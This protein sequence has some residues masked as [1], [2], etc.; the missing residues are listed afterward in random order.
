VFK[1][2]E[3]LLRIYGLDSAFYKTIEP[4]IALPH[5]TKREVPQNEVVPSK[6]KLS[7]KQFNINTAD[8]TT[9]QQLYG[10]GPTLSKRII[11]YREKLGGFVSKEQFYEIYGLD[12]MVINRLAIACFI[13]DGFE[14]KRLDINEVT[15]RE[16]EAHPYVSK[17]I[18]K[19]IV[20]Y[21]FQHGKFTAVQDLTKLQVMDTLAISKVSPYLTVR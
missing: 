11:S 7:K 21:R 2:K 16:L 8:T 20:Q 18:A 15:Q 3:D 10:I 13:E 5:K 12:S 4:W 1:V 14:P 17:N 19:A 9:L 6:P